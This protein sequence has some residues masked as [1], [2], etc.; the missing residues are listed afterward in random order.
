LENSLAIALVITAI[1][2]T[3]LF[4]SLVLFYGI[5][6]LLTAVTRERPRKP[7]GGAVAVEELGNALERRA[8]QAAAIAVS[9]ARAEAEQS[10]GAPG[11]LPSLASGDR[12]VTPWWSM[13]HQHRL[14]E[15]KAPRR[16]L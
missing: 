13:H 8:L 1:G 14:T 12:D 5:I 3:L 9:L 4:L 10:H 15:K 6:A 7:P 16:P 2:M 11:D